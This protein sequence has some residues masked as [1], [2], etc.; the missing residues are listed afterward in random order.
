MS[1]PALAI[2]IWEQSHL[3]NERRDSHPISP[4]TIR[5]MADGRGFI[6][7]HALFLLRWLGVP[8]R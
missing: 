5:K 8:R 1:W 3:L 6:C 4:A 2:A 7:Q